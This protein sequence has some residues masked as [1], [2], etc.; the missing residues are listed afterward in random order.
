[1]AHVQPSASHWDHPVRDRLDARDTDHHA[2]ERHD[3]EMSALREEN[4]ELRQ[5]V[6]YLSQLVVRN[7]L[8]REE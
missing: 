6:I 8:E 4:S 3:A 7:V 5:L 2:S 1:M